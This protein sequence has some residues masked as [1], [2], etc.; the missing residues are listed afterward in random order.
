MRKKKKRRR[1]VDLVPVTSHFQMSKDFNRDFLKR[2]LQTADPP[3]SFY[4]ERNHRT[5]VFLLIYEKNGI[6]HVLGI[7]KA[8]TPG[9]PWRNQVALPGGHIDEA[10]ESPLDGAFR[11]LA[12]EIG[13]SRDQVEVVG[14]LGHFQT[15]QQKDIEVFIGIWDGRDHGL[16]FDPS[17]ISKILEIPVVTLVQTHTAQG[18]CGR[19]PDLA[20]LIYPFEDM[21]IWGVTARIFHFFLEL[22][23]PQTDEFP[24]YR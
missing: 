15:I 17:E 21:Q 11:E 4:D 19:I 20:E 23:I 9:Y 5:A 16:C 7:L 12:E 2:L 22:L 6:P 1:P 3:G 24:E 8:D 13:I 14:S 18:F 10:D